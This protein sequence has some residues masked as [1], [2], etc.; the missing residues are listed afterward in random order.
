VGYFPHADPSELCGDG[1][2][3]SLSLRERVGV[4]GFSS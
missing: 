2:F 3:F 4:R 1:A